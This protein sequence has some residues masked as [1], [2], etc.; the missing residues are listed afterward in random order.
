[1]SIGIYSRNMAE[2]GVFAGLSRGGSPGH[3][4]SESSR[5]QAG[6][7][8][9]LILASFKDEYKDVSLRSLG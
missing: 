7:Y 4:S 1:L 6:L 9:T 8:K 5:G 3:W 2:P